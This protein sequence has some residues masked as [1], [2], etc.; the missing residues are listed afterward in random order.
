[1]KEASKNP[2]QGRIIIIIQY[3]TDK[4]TY[5]NIIYSHIIHRVTQVNTKSWGNNKGKGIY[6]ISF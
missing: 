1:M 5:K 3:F 6:T 4:N 2:T